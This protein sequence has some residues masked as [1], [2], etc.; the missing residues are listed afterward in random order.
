ML[1]KKEVFLQSYGSVLV[2]W[3][4]VSPLSWNQSHE[5]HE[6]VLDRRHGEKPYIDVIYFKNE[7]RKIKMLLIRIEA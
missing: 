7:T 5:N 2:T 3:P 1:T 6:N 4:K